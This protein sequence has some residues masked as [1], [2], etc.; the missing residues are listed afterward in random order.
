MVIITNKF[1]LNNTV[2]EVCHTQVQFL[3]LLLCNVSWC[4]GGSGSGRDCSAEKGVG[5]FDYDG[6]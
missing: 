3:S 4:G 1:K 6:S 2:L 5:G